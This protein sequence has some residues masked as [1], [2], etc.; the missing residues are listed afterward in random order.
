VEEKMPMS[1]TGFLR[2][3]DNMENAILITDGIEVSGFISGIMSGNRSVGYVSDGFPLLSNLNAIE[4]ITLFKMFHDNKTMKQAVAE[5]TPFIENL[6]ML[7]AMPKRKERLSR[8]EIINT[9]ILRAVSKAS[10]VIITDI[11]AQGDLDILK[12]SLEKVGKRLSLWI[13][14]R[15]MELGNLNLFAFKKFRLM[16][17]ICEFN[18]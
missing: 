15:E 17:G 4:N 16:G 14:C 9:Y 6:G 8:E 12:K 2:L 5:M 10:D 18:S 1:E 13:L 11:A 7:E 3:P